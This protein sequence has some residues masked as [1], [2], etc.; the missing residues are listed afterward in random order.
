MPTPRRILVAVSLVLAVALGSS[1]PRAAPADYYTLVV[2]ELRDLGTLYG[3]ATSEAHAINEH[4]AIA[5]SGETSNGTR[6]A[7]SWAT[8]SSSP[9]NLGHL[10]GGWSEAWGINDAGIVVGNSR[11][12]ANEL[13]R[14]FF[15]T[16]ASGMSDLGLVGTTIGGLKPVTAVWVTDINNNNVIVGNLGGLLIS[17]QFAAPAGFRYGGAL[18]LVPTCPNGF[19]SSTVNAINDNGFFT[20][21]VDCVGGPAAG[22]YFASLSATTNLPSNFSAA[23]TGYAINSYGV[24]AGSTL[25]T[26]PPDLHAFKWSSA[27][28]LKDIHPSNDS[29]E[30]VARGIN[31]YGLIVGRKYTDTSNRAFVYSTGINMRTLPGLCSWG[32]WTSASEAYDVNNSGWVVGKS[33]TCSGAYHATLWRVRVAGV[34]FSDQPR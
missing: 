19:L 5:G 26:A 12:T 17:N 1:Q 18:S 16:Q 11:L 15:W 9:V 34:V 21:Y 29:S 4:G 20:G 28:G 22:P 30:S 33:K 23:E 25:A 3:F 10:G 2:D 7:I 6:R 31:D 14:G 27:S 32:S 8:P 13:S 24:V